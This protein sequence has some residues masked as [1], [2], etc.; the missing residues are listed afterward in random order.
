MLLI[1]ISMK[2]LFVEVF[3]RESDYLSWLVLQ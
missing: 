2:L 3:C 1:G